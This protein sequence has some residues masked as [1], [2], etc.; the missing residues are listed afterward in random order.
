MGPWSESIADRPLPEELVNFRLKSSD[1]LAKELV[2]IN[3]AL[4]AGAKKRQKVTQ[5]AVG[6]CGVAETQAESQSITQILQPLKEAIFKIPTIRLNP[7]QQTLLSS[8]L[9]TITDMSS[10]DEDDFDTVPQMDADDMSEDELR[11]LVKCL[12]EQGKRQGV[13]SSR[14]S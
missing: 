13:S 2:S 3:D 6:H 9:A 11:A 4:P 12:L 8:S 1:E 5:D 7:S 10:L 14:S